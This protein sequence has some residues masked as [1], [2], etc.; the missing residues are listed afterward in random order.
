MPGIFGTARCDT[1]SPL[2]AQTIASMEALLRYKPFFQCDPHFSD[3]SVSAG[4]CYT[5]II[6]RERQPFSKN[7]IRVWFDGE[8]YNQ[9]GLR[10]KFD[11]TAQTDPALLVELYQTQDLK[12]FLPEIDG[13]FSSVI[14]DVSR[15]C[16]LFLNDRYGLR[17]LYIS[18]QV[19][20]IA[21]SS[22]LKALSVVPWFNGTTDKKAVDQYLRF[23]YFIEDDTWFTDVKLLPSSSFLRFSLTDG[24]SKIETYW[25]WDK[26]KP[27]GSLSD[28][29]SIGFEWGTRFRRAVE[30]RCRPG[31]KTGVT[32]S[33]GLDSRAILAAFP[34]EYGTV[35]TAT[36]GVHGCQDMSLAARAAKVKN[37][38]NHTFELSAQNWLMPRLPGVWGTDG[39]LSILDMHGIECL[40]E[41]AKIFNISLN[42]MGG[43]GIHGG[44][45]MSARQQQV[46]STKDPYGYRG[47]RFIRVGTI[48]DEPWMH[49]RLPFY[50]NDLLELTLALPA[51]IRKNARF[52]RMALL[53]AFPEYFK[54]IPWQK[55]EIPISMPEPMIMASWYLVKVRNRLEK[56]LKEIGL[57]KNKGSHNFTDYAAWLREEPG[58][59][60]FKKVLLSPKAIYPEY[61]DA[62][63][64]SGMWN[65]HCA[66][67][68]F[69]REIC[70]YATLEV[71]LQQILLKNMRPENIG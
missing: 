66:G 48:L 6:N 25:S 12:T 30:K 59:G 7:E 64:V 16:L 26:I 21:W 69:S 65:A 53:A 15:K 29:R 60:F 44:S 45:F 67:A 9:S 55:I 28:I 58:F 47:R 3:Q 8:F 10:K 36:F 70:R 71:W 41:M 56:K 2:S 37:A 52:Y 31:E 51:E 68:D 5:G 46:S 42:G 19:D 38:H 50:D 22:E 18:R 23:G 63:R 57:L 20:A 61:V 11:V 32:L 54:T 39:Q 14:Y 40:P 33:G 4:R 24:A 17:H 43:D 1:A 35:Q 49:I 27:F 62:A 13:I 34:E